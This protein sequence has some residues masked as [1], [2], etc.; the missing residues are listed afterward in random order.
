MAR[1]KTWGESSGTLGGA[2]QSNPEDGEDTGADNRRLWKKKH[3]GPFDHPE[4]SHT[5]HSKGIQE[6]GDIGMFISRSCPSQESGCVAAST[7][8]PFDGERPRSDLAKVVIPKYYYGTGIFSGSY[9]CYDNPG[10][11]QD[12]FISDLG[13]TTS[14]FVYLYS[15]YSWPNV[16]LCFV[17]GFLID[18]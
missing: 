4:G 14:E 11:L 1:V 7:C 12:N 15:W 6:G 18:R 17:G 13:L 3:D 2:E 10:A 8:V 16:V 9:F 5:H